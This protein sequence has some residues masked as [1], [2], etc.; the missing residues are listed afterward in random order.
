MFAK[1]Y[2]ILAQLNNYE[3]R[4]DKDGPENYAGGCLYQ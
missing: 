1:P 3:Y 4:G 2:L